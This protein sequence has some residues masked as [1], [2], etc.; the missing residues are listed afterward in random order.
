M[1]YKVEFFGQVVD[2]DLPNLPK[3]I[4]QR[5]LQAIENRLA[6][7]PIRY[8]LRLSQSLKGLWRMRVGDYRIAYEISGK[9]VRIWAIVHRK[10]AYEKIAKLWGK[11]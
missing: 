5:I 3:N 4:Q 8:G 2:E 6:V 9:T 11:H 7:D 10:N 1:S